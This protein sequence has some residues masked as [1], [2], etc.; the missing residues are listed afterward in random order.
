[1]IA[2]QLL[3]S[4]GFGS[5]RECRAM[6][7]RGE[8][9]IENRDIDDPDEDVGEQIGE[10]SVEGK[11]WRY[12]K[13]IVI[14][15]N[16]P[17]GYECST[18][19]SAYPS[20]LKLLPYPFRVRGIQPVGRLDVDTTGLLILT[21]DGALIHRLTS[22]KKHV[23]KIYEVLCSREVTQKMRNQLLEGVLLD[24]ERSPVKAS[25]C[26]VTGNRRLS[27]GLTQGKYHQVKRMIAAVGN[28]V[29]ELHRSRIGNYVLP[30]DLQIGEWV[31]IDAGFA[32]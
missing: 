16:K 23:E 11:R 7:L 32:F 2:E 21:D 24:G 31:W 15:L 8:L 20:V 17:K 4:Q 30:D 19:P 18:K 29:E 3:F 1:M 12:G 28:H 13:K 5:R 26:E 14:A 6:I 27:L 25:R 22:P 10:F 9:R